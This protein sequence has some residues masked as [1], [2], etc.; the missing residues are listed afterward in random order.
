[1]TF[2]R[3]GIS[4]VVC[5]TKRN[6][7]IAFASARDFLHFPELLANHGALRNSCSN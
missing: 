1:M 5:P 4:D 2:K 7:V 3:H 6:D